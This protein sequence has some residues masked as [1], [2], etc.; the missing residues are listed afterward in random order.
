RGSAL[1]HFTG[2]RWDEPAVNDLVA[3]GQGMVTVAYRAQLSRLDGERVRYRVD[4]ASSDTGT[5]FIA[6]IP[7]YIDVEAP[8]LART[9]QDSFLALPAMG[10]SLEYE[11]WAQMGTPLPSP[12]SDEER[13]R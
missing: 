5:L 9:R 7:E 1:S 11:I 3:Q 4:V 12:L 10:E 6:G 2:V 13:K 8:T